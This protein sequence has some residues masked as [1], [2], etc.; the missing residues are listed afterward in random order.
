MIPPVLRLSYS[1]TLLD[2][3]RWSGWMRG[4]SRSPP[5]IWDARTAGTTMA[6]APKDVHDFNERMVIDGD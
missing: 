1:E 6:M 5:H 3:T 4:S 2:P